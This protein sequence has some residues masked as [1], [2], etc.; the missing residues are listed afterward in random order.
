MRPSVYRQLLLTSCRAPRR[1]PIYPHAFLRSA[2]SNTPQSNLTTDPQRPPSQASK[3]YKTPQQPPS[4]ASQHPSAAK[5]IPP[6]NETPAQ[7]VARLRAARNAQK[8]AQFSLWDR[9]VV[10]GR[11]IVDTIHRWFIRF[12]IGTTGMAPR[13]SLYVLPVEGTA[14]DLQLDSFDCT[15]CNAH[16]R[17]HDALQPP[18]A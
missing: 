16:N 2:S 14:A 15:R 12:L 18:K 7:K 13:T 4:T 5:A 1:I 10:R 9:T 17:R 6:P 3:Y 8:A 11:E